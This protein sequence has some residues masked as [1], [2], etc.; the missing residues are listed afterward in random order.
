MAR[1]A[2]ILVPQLVRR[3]SIRDEEDDL[4]KEKFN[5]MMK[6]SHH[7]KKEHTVQKDSR[8]QVYIIYNCLHIRYISSILSIFVMSLCCSYIYLQISIIIEYLFL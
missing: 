1:L 6:E 7:E 4:K 8:N 5:D 2:H 3:D